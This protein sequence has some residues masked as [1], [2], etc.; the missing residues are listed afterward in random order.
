MGMTG[1]MAM[2]GALDMTGN[3]GMDGQIVTTMKTNNRASRLVR[4]VVHSS[5]TSTMPFWQP[6]DWLAS[7]R[8]LPS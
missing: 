3:L 5:A 6:A 2:N 7:N 1:D 8:P 4:V